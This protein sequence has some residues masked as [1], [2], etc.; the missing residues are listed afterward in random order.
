MGKLKKALPSIAS[1]GS[2][3]LN[4][5]LE[6]EAAPSSAADSTDKSNTI[7]PPLAKAIP[8]K[9]CNQDFNDYYKSLKLRRWLYEKDAGIGTAKLTSVNYLNFLY[10]HQLLKPIE[11][12]MMENIMFEQSK[13]SCTS[14]Q[15]S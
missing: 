6:T 7:A 2:R 3:F 1:I 13:C 9:V 15:T 11:P 5:S 4:A 12:K 14:N 8:P 10:S